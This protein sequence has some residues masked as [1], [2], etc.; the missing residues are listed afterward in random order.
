MKRKLIHV[1]L[2]ARAD[3]GIWYICAELFAKGPHKIKLVSSTVMPL[4]D[5]SDLVR[6]IYGMEKDPLIN[7]N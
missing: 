4:L 2:I 5:V 7:L 6:K 3:D 1:T